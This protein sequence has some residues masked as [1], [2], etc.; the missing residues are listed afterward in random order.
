MTTTRTKVHF[1]KSSQKNYKEVGDRLQYSTARK[2]SV[3]VLILRQKQFLTIAFIKQACSL[4]NF[5]TWTNSWTACK[6]SL[7][8]KYSWT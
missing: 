1:Y 2:N 4:E 3:T 5:I 7:T 6:D 8:T